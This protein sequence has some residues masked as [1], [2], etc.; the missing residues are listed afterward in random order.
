MT[1]Q[2]KTNKF[3]SI[4]QLPHKI[5]DA[6]GN[7]VGSPESRADFAQAL[8][9][10]LDE[11]LIR[12][13]RILDRNSIRDFE[14][15]VVQIKRQLRPYLLRVDMMNS[16]YENLLN[17]IESN[18]SKIK[19]KKLTFLENKK[20]RLILKLDK[21]ADEENDIKSAQIRAKLDKLFE[22]YKLEEVRLFNESKDLIT[23]DKTISELNISKTEED[24]K[25]FL[26]IYVL[27][28]NWSKNT[29]RYFESTGVEI[30][31]LT[32][33]LKDSL[34]NGSGV[35][36]IDRQA[37]EVLKSLIPL[38]EKYNLHKPGATNE[39]GKLIANLVSTKYCK[40]FC[41]NPTTSKHKG[42]N[43]STP[44]DRVCDVLSDFINY[45]IHTKYVGADVRSYKP[46]MYFSVGLESKKPFLKAS[47]TQDAKRKQKP[48]SPPTR[49]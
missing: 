41:K 38:K 25:L 26:S 28:Q 48:Q 17:K 27:R 47:I 29:D 42:K 15:F 31:V 34:Q 14:S 20:E 5:E 24:K 44:Y 49:K 19:S 3:I 18:F 36:E 35:S 33:K 30:K 13:F 4:E 7:R 12:V 22:E 2:V 21:Y 43:N 8:F 11:N 9:K 39:A 23:L 6:L 10:S 45:R 46:N 16:N 40:Y 32:S 37:N 1:T